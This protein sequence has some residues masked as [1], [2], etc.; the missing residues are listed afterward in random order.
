MSGPEQNLTES[1]E[2]DVVQ[3]QRPDRYVQDGNLTS[4]PFDPR[5]RADEIGDGVIDRLRTKPRLTISV[6]LVAGTLLLALLIAI[7]PF[8]PSLNNP[9]LLAA[10]AFVAYTALVFNTGAKS[11]RSR[12]AS[13]D[14]AFLKNEGRNGNG[15][16]IPLRGE[17]KRV[18]EDSIVFYPIVGWRARGYSANYLKVKH[19]GDQLTRRI[20]KT[21]MNPDD[22]AGIILNDNYTVQTQSEDFGKVLITN[23][24]GLQPATSARTEDAVVKARIPSYVDPDELDELEKKN[25]LLREDRSTL[26]GRLQVVQRQLEEL[27]AKLK[28]QTETTVNEIVRLVREL[29]STENEPPAVVN[30]QPPVARDYGQMDDDEFDEE[31]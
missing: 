27:E 23:T 29:R 16:A 28:G 21:G 12:M 4:I 15:E 10:V 9:Y 6:A 8:F 14:W 7:L 11:E 2:T 13:D 22:R 3:G 17:A 24:S 30:N 20:G 25:Q 5:V 18:D 19:V 31:Q 26:E 1:A